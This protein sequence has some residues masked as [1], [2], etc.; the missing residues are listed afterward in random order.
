MTARLFVLALTLPAVAACSSPDAPDGRALPIRTAAV[1]ADDFSVPPDSFGAYW[2]QGLAEITSYDLEQA[3]YGEIHPGEAVLIYVTEP[4]L[5]DEQVKADDADAAGAVTVLKLN[6]TREFLTGVY[7]YSMMTSVFTP[8]QREQHGPTLKVTAT[9]QEWCGHTFTQLNRV[10]DGYRLR[11]FS[12]FESE[13]DQDRTL[14]GALLEDGLWTTLRLNP[15]ALP[16]G[17]V[18][19]VPG[20][21]YQRLSHLDLE[22]QTATASLADDPEDPGLRLYTLVYP[23]LDRTLTIRFTADFPHT[24]EG[25][26][27]VR[28]SGFGPDA[29]TLTTTATRRE[30][31]MLAYWS[32]NKR[33]DVPLREALGLDN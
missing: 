24:V 4:F 27:E 22:P 23:D 32:R 20:T 21:I 17:Q 9:S 33:A 15:D 14:D 1:E 13:G 11:L 6:A 10:A 12:Y 7:P 3:R 31:D 26:T 16:T 25:W 29:E 2:Y 18:R 30:R 19:L 8:V 5:E 28:R